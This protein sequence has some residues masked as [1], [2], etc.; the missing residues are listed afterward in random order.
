[1]H[2]RLTKYIGSINYYFKEI[3]V[4]F[5]GKREVKIVKTEEISAWFWEEGWVIFLRE[6]M[7][8]R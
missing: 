2:Q 3:G 6:K 7:V 8:V 5:D 1:M 4:S